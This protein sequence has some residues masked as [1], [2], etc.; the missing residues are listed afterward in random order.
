MSHC[1]SEASFFAG[2][3]SFARASFAATTTIFA[4]R[5]PI[6]TNTPLATCTCP[7]ARAVL[8]FTGASAFHVCTSMFVA[9]VTI[10]FD[11]SINFLV[12]ERSIYIASNSHLRQTFN[13]THQMLSLLK[14]FWYQAEIF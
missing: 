10:L 9:R 5:A 11:F 3:S 6:T 12:I 2:A 1:S 14:L 13:S 7:S 4:S 8:A